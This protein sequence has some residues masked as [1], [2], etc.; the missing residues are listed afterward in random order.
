[1]CVY[2]C[3]CMV[4]NVLYGIAQIQAH[5]YVVISLQQLES[6]PRLSSIY[7]VSCVPCDKWWQTVTRLISFV[8]KE[9]TSSASI[10]PKMVNVVAWSVGKHIGLDHGWKESDTKCYTDR[11]DTANCPGTPELSLT[12]K[13]P[14]MPWSVN[15]SSAFCRDI[16]P[17]YQLH[18]INNKHIPTQ[19][20]L[21]MH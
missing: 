12:R 11:I 17:W 1:M 3:C 5:M 9:T 4:W 16:L 21:S 14:W 6:W 20:I 19:W 18:N 8:H 7:G 15:R 2:V 10:N 13:L